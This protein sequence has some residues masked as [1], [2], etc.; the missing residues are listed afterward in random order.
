MGEPAVIRSTLKAKPSAHGMHKCQKR[1]T[2]EQ[3]RP[4]REPK[5]PTEARCGH[6]SVY[7]LSR[8][9]SSLSLS[10]SLSLTNSL[11]PSLPPSLPPSLTLCVLM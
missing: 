8:R 5:R 4:T 1:P 7:S 6:V 10:L 3:K 2:R 11:T 9:L